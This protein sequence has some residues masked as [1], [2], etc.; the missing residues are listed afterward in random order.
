M[1]FVFS[2]HPLTSAIPHDIVGATQ[3]TIDM[4]RGSCRYEA[5]GCGID[6]FLGTAAS[7]FAD[8]INE[9]K[10]FFN[11]TCRIFSDLV[12]WQNRLAVGL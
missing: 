3:F 12:I 1:R 5:V 4:G 11:T 10:K 6:A 7:Y 2:K 8:D 9:A